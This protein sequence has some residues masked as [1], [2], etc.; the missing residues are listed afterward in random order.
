MTDRPILFSAPMVRALLEGR[1]TQ[2][3][4]L[5]WRKARKGESAK[6][7][8]NYKYTKAKRTIEHRKSTIWQKAEPGDR[9][10]VRETWAIDG[11]GR[12]VRTSEYSEEAF[13]FQNFIGRLQYA[14]TDTPPAVDG[15]GR[16][17]WWNLRPSIHMN[18]WASRITLVVTDVRVQR[19]QQIELRDVRL[20]GCKV[21][22][23]D[24]FGADKARR[25]TIGRIVF[26]RV[27]DE[28]NAKRAPWADN[29]EVVAITFTVHQANIDSLGET[30]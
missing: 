11:C 21:L 18:R 7:E 14:A 6:Q 29:P 15:K 2:T 30:S 20:E 5:A 13:K 19:L 16:P 26:R 22:E 8:D 12:R 9:L 17:Y 1:K 23:F 3:R 24:L 10:W 25:D 27:W 28:I 4:R